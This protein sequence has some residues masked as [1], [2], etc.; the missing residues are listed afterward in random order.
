MPE[1]PA[2]TVRAPDVNRLLIRWAPPLVPEFVD[3]PLRGVQAE[4]RDSCF[5]VGSLEVGHIW[6][7]LR[8][9]V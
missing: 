7:Y 6:L 2:H 3:D 5:V 8:G 9:L 4:R 1:T